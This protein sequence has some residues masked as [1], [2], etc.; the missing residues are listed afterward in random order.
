M[1]VVLIDHYWFPKDW[2]FN[3]VLQEC[4]ATVA[5]WIC[6]ANF[7]RFNSYEWS[8][9]HNTKFAKRQFQLETVELFLKE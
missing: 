5:S 3:W 7:A 2:Q 8:W 6:E 1:Q 4:D 9:E